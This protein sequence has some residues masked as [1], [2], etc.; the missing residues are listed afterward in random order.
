MSR[1][2][3]LSQLFSFKIFCNLLRVVIS[4]EAHWLLYLLEEKKATGPPDLNFP[5]PEEKGPACL[6]KVTFAN[7][8]PGL[9]R[10]KFFTVEWGIEWH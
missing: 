2:D 8:T 5:L 7:N 3:K 1:R 6:V 10:W 9:V 4:F